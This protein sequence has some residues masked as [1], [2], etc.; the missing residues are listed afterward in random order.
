M[1][2]NQHNTARLLAQ[3]N[4][5][6]SDKHA[7]QRICTP[8][9]MYESLKTSAGA[10]GGGG[11]GGIRIQDRPPRKKTNI[12]CCCRLS[13]FNLHSCHV[14]ASCCRCKCLKSSFGAKFTSPAFH[15]PCL[16]SVHEHQIR[17]LRCGLLHFMEGSGKEP[18][19]M[20]RMEHR[21]SQCWLCPE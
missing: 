9:I 7:G 1:R 8:C 5:I 3:N 18:F 2:K 10:G 13:F 16:R 11:G 12:W 6:W 21:L 4:P 19:V 20:S 17:C 14:F 15:N